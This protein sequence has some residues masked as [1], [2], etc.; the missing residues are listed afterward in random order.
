MSLKR[1]SVG[2]CIVCSI[3]IVLIW[4]NAFAQ[5][6]VKK[7]ANKA[8]VQ[9]KVGFV[10][11]ELWG[12]NVVHRIKISVVNKS[13]VDATGVRLK[14]S[15][16]EN[17]PAST[18]WD[19]TPTEYTSRETSWNLGRLPPRSQF[20]IF[21]DFQTTMPIETEFFVETADQL[22][23]PFFI[24]I[25]A[26]QKPLEIKIAPEYYSIEKYEKSKD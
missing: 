11:T 9:L 4:N 19:L 17:L 3:S 22:H 1:L 10:G 25:G 5:Q 21:G 16:P 26:K 14:I 13:D 8:S 24:E 12:N 6:A 7:S 20:E 23:Q 15:Y 18:K 2:W